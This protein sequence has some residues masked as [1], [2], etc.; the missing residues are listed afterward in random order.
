MHERL[1]QQLKAGSFHYVL[2]AQRFS[3]TTEQTVRYLNSAL[4]AA[5]FYGVELVRFT[6]GET[7]A[8]EART[9]LKPERLSSAKSGAG[10]MDESRFLD[11]ILDEE[12]KNAL[13]EILEACRGLGL[14]FEWGTV[15]TSIRVPTPDRAEPLTIGW[16]FPSG[17]LGWMG[18]QS[19]EA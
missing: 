18:L 16:L 10:S 3:A 14:R 7:S 5:R 6:G 1:L 8:F 15:G 13:Q 11:S 4:Q 17:G 12:Y 9:I 19:G 2:V